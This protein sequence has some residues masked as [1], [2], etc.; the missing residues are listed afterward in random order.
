MHSDTQ[1]RHTAKEA[2]IQNTAALAFPI[3]AVG[4]GRIASCAARNPDTE[5]PIQGIAV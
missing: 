5:Q 3:I 4:P 2:Q 1:R